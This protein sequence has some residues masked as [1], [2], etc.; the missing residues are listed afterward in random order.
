MSLPGPAFYDDEAVFATYQQRR[1]QPDNPNDL[2]EKPIILATY[3]RRQRIP[4]FLLM[5][6]RKPPLPHP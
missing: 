2:L 6:G 5:A 3:E 1:Q 4:L